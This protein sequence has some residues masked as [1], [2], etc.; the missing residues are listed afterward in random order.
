MAI[1]LW[2]KIHLK[3]SVPPPPRNMI[4]LQ[5]KNPPTML[6]G[7]S[8][9]RKL[10]VTSGSGSWQDAN[11][12]VAGTLLSCNANQKQLYIE[13]RKFFVTHTAHNSW[14]MVLQFIHS[15]ICATSQNPLNEI[16]FKRRQTLLRLMSPELDN[17]HQ[18]HKVYEGL[19]GLLYFEISF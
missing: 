10:S 17:S 2:P 14:V 11:A 13:K 3:N 5:K 4:P 9:K 1:G 19:I 15:Q 6:W 12:D 7:D 18:K 16:I 8:F